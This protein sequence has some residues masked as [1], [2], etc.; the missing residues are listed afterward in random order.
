MEGSQHNELARQFS[1]QREADDDTS[2]VIAEHIEVIYKAF[3]HLTPRC[4]EGALFQIM[5]AS[6][7]SD[8]TSDADP[9]SVQKAS[10]RQIERLLYRAVSFFSAD[11]DELPHSREYMMSR[12]PDPALNRFNHKDA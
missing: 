5:C 7:E 9:L 1:D 10:K 11:R 3:S 4:I 8:R 2:D 6:A 12:E